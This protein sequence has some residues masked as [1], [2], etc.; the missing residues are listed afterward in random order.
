MHKYWHEIFSEV[1]YIISIIY[2]AYCTDITL[3]KSDVNANIGLVHK[4]GG[5][6]SL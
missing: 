2:N 4:G 1:P 5:K 3:N 6:K